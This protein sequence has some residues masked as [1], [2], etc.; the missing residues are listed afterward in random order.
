MEGLSLLQ[1]D[2]LLPRPELRPRTRRSRCTVGA[3]LHCNLG[4]GRAVV[5][6]EAVR[7]DAL[8]VRT[9]HSH[10]PSVAQLTGL[11]YLRK[12]HSTTSACRFIL[13]NLL[14]LA[15]CRNQYPSL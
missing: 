4:R 8:P 5:L 13:S 11:G 10:F 14:G 2:I 12:Y 9:H 1:L 3:P 15:C 6:C 7:A